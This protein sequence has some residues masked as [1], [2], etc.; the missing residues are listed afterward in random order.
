MD[1]SYVLKCT[2][3]GF[4]T[5]DNC[6]SKNT[7]LLFLENVQILRKNSYSKN[8]NVSEYGPRS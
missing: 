2:S 1:L 6:Y 4:L 5:Y 3:A 7:K 8:K